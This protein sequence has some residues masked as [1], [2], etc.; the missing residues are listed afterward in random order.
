MLSLDDNNSSFKPCINVSPTPEKRAIIDSDSLQTLRDSHKITH[1][2]CSVPD[3]LSNDLAYYQKMSDRDGLPYLLICCPS[4]QCLTIIPQT[5]FGYENRPYNYGQYD[6]YSLVRD[7]LL[8]EKGVALNDYPREAYSGGSGTNIF[9]V[10]ASTEGFIKVEDVSLQSGDVLIFN[11][12]S[13]SLQPAAVYIGNGQMLHHL[14]P[15][16]SCQETYN[17]NWK[18]RISSVWRHKYL[19]NK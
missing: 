19:I 13:T 5:E 2:I 14:S 11:L 17:E 8:K 15:G 10:Q 4:Q 18:K 3:A 12:P 16:Q 6:C 7:Y 1:I 9:E